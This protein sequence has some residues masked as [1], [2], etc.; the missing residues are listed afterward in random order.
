MVAR[1][2]SRMNHSNITFFSVEE[3]FGKATSK[4]VYD[5]PCNIG[6]LSETL[7]RS[8][9]I[10][11]AE[12]I[13]RKHTLYNLYEHFVPS[14]LAGRIYERM[15]ENKGLGLHSSL[16]LCASYVPML[17]YFKF[18]P[19][20]NSEFM[21]KYGEFYILRV[22]QNSC[23]NVC[24]YH[25]TL[26]ID[27]D[28][29]IRNYK[30]V[31]CPKPENMSRLRITDPLS[32]AEMAHSIK[33]AEA[34]DYIISGKYDYPFSILRNKY[35][36]LLK[37]HGL[38]HGRSGVKISK[39]KEAFRKCYGEAFL[40]KLG[41]EVNDSY[42]NWLLAIFRKHQRLFH[43]IRHILV[44]IFLAE[45]IEQFCN[46]I[47]DILLQPDKRKKMTL[48]TILAITIG[49]SLLYCTSILKRAVRGFVI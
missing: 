45:S 40:R 32:K 31:V 25:G 27:S 35:L 20:C 37:C 8:H 22:H 1:Y 33:I 3:L 41:C 36:N 30:K 47:P 49:K 5:L 44:I 13:I 15:L 21:S 42:C 23:I 2:H 7:K 11:P 48:E 10:Y 24:P 19:D 29:D 18:C 28:I 26:L 38:L 6:H 34:F 4:V 16:G 39:L 43:P 46:F 9:F 12:E 17:K 14:E